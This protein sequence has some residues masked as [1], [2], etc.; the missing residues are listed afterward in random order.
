MRARATVLNV[1]LLSSL[2]HVLRLIPLPKAFFAPLQSITHG[3]LTH[4]MFPKVAYKRLLRPRKFGGLAIL[5]PRSQQLALQ[6]HWV[7]PLLTAGHTGLSFVHNWLLAILRS[8]YHQADVVLQLLLPTLRAPF[9]SPTSTFGLLTRFMDLFPREWSQVRLSTSLALQ[10]PIVD[11]VRVPYQTMT[12][13]TYNMLNRLRVRRVLV[14]DVYIFD[15]RIGVVR[16]RFVT[17]LVRFPNIIRQLFRLFDSVELS[18]QHFFF[19]LSL[20]ASMFPRE[21]DPSANPGSAF[22]LIPG[23]VLPASFT[24]FSSL[25]TPCVRNMS[26]NHIFPSD[27]VGTVPARKWQLFWSLDIPHS[28]R[29]VRFRI[30]HGKISCRVILHRLAPTHFDSPSCPLCN[31]GEDSVDHFRFSCPEKWPI[32]RRIWRESFIMRDISVDAVRDALYHPE[33]PHDPPV[34]PSYRI[35]ACI[36]QG[37]W[38][39]HWRFVFDEVPFQLDPICLSITRQIRHAISESSIT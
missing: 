14:S 11:V 25:T 28:V 24:S 29:T 35:I 18:V 38:N 19:R 27:E 30:L 39:A 32:W 6:L 3:F 15:S 34:I 12:L 23:L 36:L 37:I 8:L 13:R 21:P 7:Q 31:D 9:L 2:W 1:L 17:E 22:D 26:I 4:R 5:D 10:L 20:P 16:R 33:F